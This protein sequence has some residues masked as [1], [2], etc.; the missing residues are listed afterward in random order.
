MKKTLLNVQFLAT[1]LALSS[2]I[3][4]PAT[5]HADTYRQ[6]MN[7]KMKEFIKSNPCKFDQYYYA[8][9]TAQNSC[10]PLILD[11][12]MAD[13]SLS[14]GSDEFKS[15]MDN[16]K[17]SGIGDAEELVSKEGSRCGVTATMHGDKVTVTSGAAK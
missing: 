3:L 17:R 12:L 5:V 16:K 10:G 6:C 8:E 2:P 9:N 14:L 11:E 7:S 13:K 1:I 4:L 15:A